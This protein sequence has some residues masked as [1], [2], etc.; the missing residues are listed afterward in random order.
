MKQLHRNGCYEETEPGKPNRMVT[1]GQE[2]VQAQL[3]QA[4]WCSLPQPEAGLCR[5]CCHWGGATWAV[6]FQPRWLYCSVTCCCSSPRHC[7]LLR[8]SWDIP[9]TAKNPVIYTYLPNQFCPADCLQAG[10]RHQEWIG[11]GWA[12]PP[13]LYKHRLLVNFGPWSE[14]MSWSP[15]LLSPFSPIKFWPPTQ[16]PS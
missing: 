5:P 13:P 15:L 14:N 6:A 4:V 12:S 16:E 7:Y 11:G 9:E 10:D 8:G 3:L 1:W 2:R